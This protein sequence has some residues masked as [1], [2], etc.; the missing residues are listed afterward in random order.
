MKNKYILFR[1]GESVPNL[2]K[3]VCSSLDNG[4]M[5]ENGL[6][7]LGFEQVKK[8]AIE[9]NKILTKSDSKR[10]ILISSP[11]S[12]AV[13]TSNVLISKLDIK[14][15]EFQVDSRLS[16]RYFGKYESGPNNIYEKVWF[17]DDKNIDFGSDIETPIEVSKRI[18]I[19]INDLENRFTNST[20]LLVSH[21]D[22]LMIAKTFF[23][24]TN[25]YSHHNSEYL[26]NAQYIFIDI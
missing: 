23:N 24:N 5:L 20:I 17:A 6:T 8:S 9:L 2:N 15:S 10:I 1:H 22:T 13:Q 26:K 12:R 3:Q 18:E 11:F 16:E 7:E 19:L 25:P 4:Q 21:G 14:Y